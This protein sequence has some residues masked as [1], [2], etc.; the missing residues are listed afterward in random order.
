M[1]KGVLLINLG[2]PDDPSPE[3]VSRYL[4]EFLMDAFVVD[5]P[6]FFR[7]I[8]VY[9]LVVPRRKFVA[10]NA[11][12][13][14]WRDKSP[15]LAHSVDLVREVGKILGDRYICKLGMRYGN[16][17]IL[18]ALQELKAEGVTQLL[19]LP[20]YPQYALSSTESS[21]A[22]V[23]QCLVQLNWKVD[24]VFSKDFFDRSEF[25]DPLSA[26]IQSSVSLSE[27]DCLVFSFHGLPVRHVQKLQDYK[28]NC[29][30][31]SSCCD[32]VSE[33]NRW[34]YRAQSFATA[35]GLAKK[36]NLRP[37]QYI[38]TFQSRLGRTEWI[39]PFTD[40]ELPKLAR[41]GKR[42][43]IVCPS[44]TNDCLE[45]LEEIDIRARQEFMDNG[46]KVFKYVPCLNS[47]P[48][49]VK[50]LS[51]L[52]LQMDPITGDRALQL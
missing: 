27:M 42:V 38:V 24:L 6:T 40:L 19:V 10:S 41:D 33:T 44:F 16:P 34:C 8:L 26:Q 14:I 12:K 35:R 21:L 43:A 37:D 20:L 13:K 18:S 51:S 52:I 11:Y 36:L 23:K 17:K 4:K 46:G 30:Q 5:I 29:Y 50:G 28:S 2:T 45:T 1:K 9:I 47:N 48:Q 32:R 22:M 15:L 3:S 49:W 25:I 31:T 7:W 39:K